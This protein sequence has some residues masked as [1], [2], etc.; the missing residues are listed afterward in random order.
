MRYFMLTSGLP[1][2][3]VGFMGLSTEA[4]LASALIHSAA[5]P[6][7]VKVSSATYHI[8]VETGASSLSE[9]HIKVPEP[10]PAQIRI[11]QATVTTQAGKVVSAN[12]SFNGKEVSIIFSQPVPAGTTL[13]IDLNNVQT[14]DLIGRTW[15]FPV[16]GKSIG[17][18]QEISLGMT[19]IQTRK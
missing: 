9:I 10:A 8:G 4:S 2:L 19:R 15:Q 3:L 13:E 16:Y 12:S 1:A 18:N 7:R 14:S 17:V 6:D 5:Y 11:G